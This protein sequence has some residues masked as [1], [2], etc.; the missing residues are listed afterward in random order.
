MLHIFFI[1][2]SAIHQ[3]PNPIEHEPCVPPTYAKAMSGLLNPYAQS[4]DSRWR[5]K[6]GS[7]AR[8]FYDA[9]TLCFCFFLGMRPIYR[10]GA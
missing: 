5:L 4:P 7:S 8:R 6:A 2:M 9:A 1:Y 10:L 3:L